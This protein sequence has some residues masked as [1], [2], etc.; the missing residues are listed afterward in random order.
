MKNNKDFRY[1]INTTKIKRMDLQCEMKMGHLNKTQCFN[2]NET[3]R[4]AFFL[5]HYRVTTVK[6][7][8]VDLSQ[9]IR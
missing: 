8:A 1:N 2:F 9:K 4:F 7:T 3:L 6:F 5:S